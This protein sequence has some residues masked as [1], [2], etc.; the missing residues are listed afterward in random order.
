VLHNIEGVLSAIQTALDEAVATSPPPPTPP[1]HA[2]RGW[3]GQPAALPSS[4][5]AAA[6]PAQSNASSGDAYS[7]PDVRDAER[8]D[9][10]P[11]ARSAFTRVF[12]ALWRWGGVRGGGN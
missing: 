11:P 12:D 8:R 2:S 7:R 9:S 5:M 10:P 3:R 1:R 6:T 4:Q